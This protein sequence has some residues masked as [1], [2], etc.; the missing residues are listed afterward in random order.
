MPS[1]A[2]Q[3]KMCS[4]KNQGLRSGNLEPHTILLLCEREGK[5]RRRRKRKKRRRRR[6]RRRGRR[7]GRGREGRREGRQGGR[8]RRPTS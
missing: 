2:L 7:R 3:R 1:L 6:R 5:R 8:R 4:V